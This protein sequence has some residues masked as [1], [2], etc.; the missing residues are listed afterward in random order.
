[1]RVYHPGHHDLAAGE[2][3]FPRG[4][5]AQITHG[6]DL[7][8]LDANIHNGDTGGQDCRAV[9]EHQIIHSMSP[10][11]RLNCG[12]NFV[13]VW[14]EVVLQAGADRERGVGHP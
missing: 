10:K 3:Y 1:M 5:R 9:F 8:R 12:Y 13:G 7:P 11:K 6:G 14:Q 4:L 2:H